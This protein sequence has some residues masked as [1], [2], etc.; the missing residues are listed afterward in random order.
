MLNWL[1]RPLKCKFG[2]HKLAKNIH[3]SDPSTAIIRTVC[4]ECDFKSSGV[5]IKL[6][7]GKIQPAVKV[8]P[9]VKVDPYAVNHAI[10]HETTRWCG[11]CM[12][13]RV[14]LPQIYT[15]IRCKGKLVD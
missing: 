11:T 12:E 7:D 9:V 2:G 8:I 4:T 3:H 14:V 6:V 13:N 15:C 5:G 1:S 10:Y